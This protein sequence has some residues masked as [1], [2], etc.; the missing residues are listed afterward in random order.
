MQAIKTPVLIVGG[1]PVGLA[2]AGDLG[3][4]GVPC[5]R[6][7]RSDG[8]IKQAKMDMVGIRSMEFC[9]RWG[10]VRWVEEAGYNRDYPQDCAWVTSLNGYEFGRE[11]FSAPS[12]EQPPPQSPQKRERC[13]QNFFDPVLRRFA[14]RSSHDR[15]QYD[16][17][18][19]D[20]VEQDSGVVA[21]L[22][23]TPDGSTSLVGA[24]YLVGADGGATACGRSS[25]SR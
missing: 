1:G 24:D 6:I 12:R 4:R 16:T 15:L 8:V 11:P 10:I 14:E 5:M 7:E 22:R 20:F 2:L 25:A 23:N 3:W 21:A 13:P 19:V 18:L 9:R 17:E